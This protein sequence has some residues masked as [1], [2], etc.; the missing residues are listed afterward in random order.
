MM[1]SYLA[2]TLA[3]ICL[4]LTWVGLIGMTVVFWM[5]RTDTLQ[6]REELLLDDALA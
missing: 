5:M 4:F 1:M 2:E 6:T 3:W